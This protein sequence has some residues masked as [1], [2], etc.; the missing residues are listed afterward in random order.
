MSPLHPHLCLPTGSVPYRTM[1]PMAASPKLVKMRFGSPAPY[2]A[3]HSPSA[4]I[5]E[6]FRFPGHVTQLHPQHRR[7]LNM[8]HHRSRSQ[9]KKVYDSQIDQ[10][11]CLMT[12]KEKAWIIKLQMIQLQSENPFLQDYYYQEFYR[13][14][15]L[16]LADEEFG[17]KSKHEPPKLVTPYVQ[18]AENYEAVVH[19]EGSLG[20]VAMS[21]CYSPR[22]AIDAVHV[23]SSDEDLKTVGRERLCLLNTIEKMYMVLLEVEEMDKR[24]ALVGEGERDTMRENREAKIKW[25]YESLNISRC[26]REQEANGFSQVLGVQKGKKL[27]S[28]MLAVLPAGHA[29]EVA[30]AIAARLSVLVQ[31]DTE[32]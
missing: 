23:T 22:R 9:P 19:I 24:M 15:E 14:L 3:I 10:Y 31:M 6:T 4:N 26:E 7:I 16:K 28:R 5:L 8:R 11:S 21:T 29:F 30:F 2:A 18:K 13:K 27:V 17:E 1:S 12:D 25:L 20:Q 32:Q